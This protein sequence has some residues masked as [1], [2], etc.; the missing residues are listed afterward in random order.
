MQVCP[1]LAHL[2][3]RMR[4]LQRARSTA[5]SSMMVG[6][7]PPSSSTQGVRCSAAARRTTL[8]TRVLPVKKMW[9][10]LQES[11]RNSK[12]H[13]FTESKSRSRDVLS[14]LSFS[15]A[16]VIVASPD[17]AEKHVNSKQNSEDNS[18]GTAGYGKAITVQIIEQLLF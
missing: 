15:S 3:H 9:S 6:D 7:L 12:I 5:E 14:C 13:R 4:L 10:H 1:K 17:N 11:Q 2:P 8:P 18:T 16:V